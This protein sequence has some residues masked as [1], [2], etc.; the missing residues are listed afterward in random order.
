MSRDRRVQRVPLS[1]P[2]TGR[3]GANQ[4]VV[5]DI[6]VLGARIEH[7]TPLG[8]AAGDTGTLSFMLEDEQVTVDCRVVRSRLERLSVGAHGLT[9]YHSGLQFLDPALHTRIQLKNII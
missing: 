7:H 6:S 1:L 5:V 2:V 4:V 9:V 3:F 8:T